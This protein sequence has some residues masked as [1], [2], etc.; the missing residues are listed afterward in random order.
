LTNLFCF[1]SQKLFIAEAKDIN[2]LQSYAVYARDRVNAQVF[3]YALSVALLH[4]PDTKN[5]DLPLYIETFPNKFLDSRA[6]FQAR[7][8]AS[9][10]PMGSRRPIIIPTDYTA[11]N[12]ELEHVLWY[13][14]E[15]LGINLHH[16]HWHLVYPFDASDRAIVAKDRRGEIFYY[17]H[18]QIIARYDFER[19]CNNLPRT[20]RLNNLRIP[21]PEGYFSKLDSLIASRSYPPRTSNA[22]LTDI[23]RQNEQLF[24]RISDMELW[25]SRFLEAIA[26]GSV[27]D[28]RGQRQTLTIETGIDVLGNMM[29]SSLLSPNQPFYGDLHNMGHFLISYQHDPMHN[30]LES[31]GVMGDSGTAM[32]DP[33]FYRFHADMDD[34]FQEYKKKL[35]PYSEQELNYS[36][37]IIQGVQV[38]PVNGR[39]NIL[40]TFWQQSDVIN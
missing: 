6:F 30:H 3:N 13:F 33:V 16:W 2:Q 29:E 25:K 10:M 39:S 14:R 40:N 9:I 15:D 18:Q 23:N 22:L 35:P 21:I 38:Q 4:R 37:I 8:E 27:V 11:S 19:L 28:S 20:T 12:N 24:L 5:L 1:L 7:Q 32:R 17:M 31:Y 34:I 36:G 26:A